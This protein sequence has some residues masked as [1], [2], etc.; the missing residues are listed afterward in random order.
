MGNRIIAEDQGK[1]IVA[2]CALLRNIEGQI[3]FVLSPRRGV[4]LPGGTV[5]NNESP[6][7]TALREL[8]EETGIVATA[9]EETPFYDGITDTKKR[10]QTFLV[11][12]WTG[13]VR[14]SIEGEA[15]WAPPEELIGGR[16]AYPIYN[17]NV[18]TLLMNRKK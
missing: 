8:E 9:Y 6:L 17:G 4:G 15:Y 16:A 3:L 11:T 14:S 10:A 7:E 13:E 1:P 5:D 18:L 2:A 12:A